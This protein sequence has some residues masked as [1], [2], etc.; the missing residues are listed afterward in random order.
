MP[1]AMIWALVTAG[2]PVAKMVLRGLGVGMVTYI[3]INLILTEAS[4]IILSNFLGLPPEIQQMFGLLKVDIAVN[5]ILSAITTKLTLSGVNKMTDHKTK[6][7]G[8]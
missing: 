3:G 5:I 8:I 2:I 6:L 7:T 4:D 1:L